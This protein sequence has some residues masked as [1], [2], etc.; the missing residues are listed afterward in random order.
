MDTEVWKTL[1]IP[2]LIILLPIVEILGKKVLSWLHSKTKKGKEIAALKEAQ[3]KQTILDIKQNSIDNLKI[4]ENRLIDALHDSED[5]LGDDLNAIN[6]EIEK[7][8]KSDIDMRAD[9]D[10]LKQISQSSARLELREQYHFYKHQGWCPE[11][12]KRDIDNLH[13]LYSQLGPNGD[14]DRAHEEFMNL[15]EEIPE[16]YKRRSTDRKKVAK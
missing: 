1:I 5:R 11:D 13:T 15:P 12:T 3:A 7:Q 9:I 14:M 10:L 4:S 2:L 8:A 16:I 6:A